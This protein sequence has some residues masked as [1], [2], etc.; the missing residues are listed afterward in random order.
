VRLETPHG[1]CVVVTGDTRAALREAGI[2]G[3]VARDDRGAPVMPAGW[4]G[5]LSHK[6]ELA[7]ALVAEDDGS[8]ARI[9]LDLEEAREPRQP[10]E[11]R[12]L[13]ARELAGLA[14]RRDITRFF[15]IKEAIYKAID[16]FVR[17][18]VGFQ[19]VEI[20]AWT[21]VVTQLPFS[22]DVWSCERDGFWIA[23]ARVLPA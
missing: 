9:G 20:E 14:S 10:I 17:R 18:Y 4:L 16:P 19:E 21:R 7:A 3:D 8:G 22:I 13:T 2:A 5:S 15:A 23:T 1:L 12:V 6:R 11:R